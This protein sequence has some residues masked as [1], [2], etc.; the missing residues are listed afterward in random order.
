MSEFIKFRDAVNVQFKKMVAG[1][2][3]F[4]ANVDKDTLSRVYLESFPEGSNPLFRERTQHDCSGCN[5]FIRHLGKVVTID[6][7]LEIETVWDI[8]VGGVYQE[9]AD[10]LA[11]LVRSAKI[12]SLYR[13]TEKRYGILNNT[14]QFEDGTIHKWDHF[15][16]EV[17]VSLIIRRNGSRSVGQIVGEYNTT[18]SVLKRSVTEITNHA[19]D[20][21]EDLIMQNSLY[22]GQ[23]HLQTVG[24]LKTLKSEYDNLPDDKKEIFLWDCV[25]K[26]G[27]SVRVKNTVIGTLL[28]DLS[29]GVELERAVKSFEDKVAPQNYKRTTALITQKMID[30]ANNTIKKLEI[31]DSLHRRY[32][33]ESDLTINNVLFADRDSK[34]HVNSNPLDSLKPTKAQNLSLDKVQ[35]ITIDKFLSDVLPKIETMEVYVGNKHTS[36][37]MS[38][39]APVHHDSKSLLSWDN[40]FSWSY[41]GEV[42][43]SIQERVKSAG[44]SVEGDMRVSLSWFNYD[45][46]DLHLYEP[47]GNHV[48]YAGARS[49]CGN[50]HLDV[51]MNAGGKHSREAVENIVFK[52]G[53]KIVNG[54]YKVRVH[55][56]TKRETKDVGFDIQVSMF[57]EIFNYHFPK[58]VKNCEFVDVGEFVVHNGDIK[59][60][61]SEEISSTSASVE[62]WGINTEQFHKVSMV[63]NSPNHWDGEA[64]G[65]KHFFFIIDECKNPSSTR[66]IYNEFLRPELIE[67]R[68]VFEVLGS[69]LKAEYSDDQLSGVGFSST[70]NDSVIVKVG[71]SFNRTLKINF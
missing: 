12:T 53:N 28:V 38:L 67:H 63:L 61:P 29:E 26:Y 50:G 65:N 49:S 16:A 36:N 47:N 37:F 3:A 42:T 17:P 43:D 56:F 54:R 33:V 62:E 52:D 68:K 24:K 23:E 7:Q 27:H 18:Y 10:A 13:T 22:R 4:I 55:N 48:Y 71:G 14:E 20:T 6:S 19:I 2:E 40:G 46:L 59:F 15:Y 64:K 31:E 60:E 39:I 11:E 66:G 44:G 21:V 51:D 58:D 41:N 9:V 1:G 57:G 30:N 70:K 5:N 69:K 25:A 35:E 45:D 34:L 32:A 8:D